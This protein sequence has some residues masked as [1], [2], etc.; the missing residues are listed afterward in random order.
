MD[1]WKGPPGW[2]TELVWGVA[3]LLAGAMCLA[4]APLLP[5]VWIAGRM[6]DAADR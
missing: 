6:T 1:P 3:A 4:L 5:I 2:R